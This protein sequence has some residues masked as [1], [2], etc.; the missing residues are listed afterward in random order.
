MPDGAHVHDTLTGHEP[1]IAG[2]PRI[3]LPKGEDRP[4]NA[5]IDYKAMRAK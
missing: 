4:G 1:I 3:A 2:V 5:K